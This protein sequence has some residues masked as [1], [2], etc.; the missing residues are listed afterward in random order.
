MTVTVV[1]RTRPG[2]QASAVLGALMILSLSIGMLAGRILPEATKVYGQAGGNHGANTPCNPPDT[3]YTSALQVTHQTGPSYTGNPTV[4]EPD[5]GESFAITGYWYPAAGPPAQL[6][7]TGTADVDW[8]GSSWVLS[9]GAGF[10][11]VLA[12]VSICQGDTC[13]AGGGAVHSWDFKLIVDVQ[14]VYGGLYLDH[15]SYAT[16][17]VDDGYTVEDPTETQGDCYLGTAVQPTSQSFGA[18][19]YHADWGAAGKCPF[20][21]TIT[22]ASMTITYD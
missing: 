13:N 18:S 1:G 3:T 5:T 14:G 21:C 12:A 19:E 6:M 15:V 11:G 2:R 20:N 9:N 22:G 7:A 8:N 10:G 4:V 16:T 17:A